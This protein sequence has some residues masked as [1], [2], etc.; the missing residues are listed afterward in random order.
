M[1]EPWRLVVRTPAEAALVAHGVTWIQVQLADGA[2]I[3]ILPGH[4]PLL[5][6]TMA[7]PLRYVDGAGEHS[8]EVNAG[9]LHVTRAEVIVYTTGQGRDV[10]KR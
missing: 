1:F 10:A 7:A 9:L 6:E 2:P 8:L 5:A 3:T 4:A